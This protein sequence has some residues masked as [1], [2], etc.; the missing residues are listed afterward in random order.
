M[1]PVSKCSGSVKNIDCGN[2]EV[3]GLLILLCVGVI[4]KGPKIAS[5]DELQCH[6]RILCTF[7]IICS[8]FVL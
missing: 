2:T 3:G 1:F 4:D 6:K 5:R 7:I 8:I